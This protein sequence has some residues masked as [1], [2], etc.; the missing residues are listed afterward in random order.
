MKYTS[1]AIYYYQKA[2]DLRPQDGRMWKALASCYS[3][4]KQDKEAENYNRRAEACDRRSNKSEMIQIARI[5]ERRGKMGVAIDFY[6]EVWQ[7][8]VA[9]N[10]IDEQIA[11]ICLLLARYALSIGRLSDAEQYA[12]PALNMNHPYNED[13]RTIIDEVRVRMNSQ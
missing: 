12:I 9:S 7:R 2:T 10:S 4:L 3:T 8:A 6:Q 1:D 5:F 11:D 13:A